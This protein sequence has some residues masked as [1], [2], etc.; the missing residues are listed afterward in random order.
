MPSTAAVNYGKRGERREP[1]GCR[2]HA[3]FRFF[4]A[5][6]GPAKRQTDA[7][8]SNIPAGASDGLSRVAWMLTDLSVPVHQHALC[9]SRLEDG[10]RWG[11]NKPPRCDCGGVSAFFI[12]LLGQ[13]LFPFRESHCS[14][15]VSLPTHLCGIPSVCL[16]LIGTV[17]WSSP[18]FMILRVRILVA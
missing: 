18:P 10:G 12:Q 7:D 1:H 14:L 6:K 8:V 11:K 17:H 16:P 2:L 13:H 4:C 3:R 9:V 15:C 5:V